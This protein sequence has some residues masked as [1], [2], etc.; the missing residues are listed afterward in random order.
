WDAPKHRGLTMFIVNLRAPGITI[1]PIRQV[2]GSAEFCQEYFDDVAVPA[3]DVVGDVN[4]GW[5][6][7]TRLLEHEHFAVGGDSPYGSGPPYRF[8]D[9]VFRDDIPRLARESGR[10][11]D[12]RVR[13]MVAEAHA[14]GLVHEHLV[15]RVAR[16][17]A[18]GHYPRAAGA[19][20]K[21]LDAALVVR[22]SDMTIELTG[23]AG[24]AWPEH[25]SDGGTYAR[26]YLF[27]QAYCIGGGTTE[28]QRNI[29]SERVLGMPREVSPDR[30]APFRDVRHN[31]MPGARP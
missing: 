9:Y 10:A 31:P 6:V 30:D 13:Q 8:A 19:I 3:S 17:V 1:E 25:D 11:G 16:G 7:A 18:L 4:G 24:V 15:H 5:T 29:V 23:A 21:L 28:I 14:L 2:N 27:R 26:Q 20:T 22:C 12:P